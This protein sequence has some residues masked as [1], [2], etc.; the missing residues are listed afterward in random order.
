[1]SVHCEPA[2]CALTGEAGVRF[3]SLFPKLGL[4]GEREGVPCPF[5]RARPI[6]V[7]QPVASVA[8]FSLSAS[9]CELDPCF[10]SR[11]TAEG[12]SS[13]FCPS[14]GSPS[15]VTPDRFSPKPWIRPL[16][17]V[18][19]SSDTQAHAPSPLQQQ[20]SPS[21]V[22]SRRRL[23][24]RSGGEGASCR[25]R[26]LWGHGLSTFLSGGVSWSAGEPA[27][28]PGVRESHWRMEAL[29]EGVLRGGVKA[30]SPS[31][32][33]V[34]E[35]RGRSAPLGAQEAGWGEARG[36]RLSVPVR[37]LLAG[38]SSHLLTLT[39]PGGQKEPRK[40]KDIKHLD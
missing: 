39:Q 40:S 19:F 25:S 6:T 26:G 24:R 10:P 29:E 37:G 22:V 11:S 30:L 35:G 28:E 20:A 8:L 33:G 21:V 17:A 18:G 4:L 2:A 15:R 13:L 9:E 34:L 3:S 14:P 27:G 38:V 5:C 31:G 12:S 16:F 36:P 7:S 1:M 32:P 23:A